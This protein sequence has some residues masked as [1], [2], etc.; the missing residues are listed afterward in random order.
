MYQ[1]GAAERLENIFETKKNDEIKKF[2]G[3]MRNGEPNQSNTC[4]RG[5]SIPVMRVIAPKERTTD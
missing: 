1:A 4:M 2:S 3:R 5:I